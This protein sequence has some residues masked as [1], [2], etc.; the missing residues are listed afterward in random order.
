MIEAGVGALVDHSVA[1]RD[2]PAGPLTDNV[3]AVRSVIALRRT[4]KIS[5]L[6]I[7]NAFC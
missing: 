1:Q 7:I 6:G 3:T 2:E 5:E 4:H